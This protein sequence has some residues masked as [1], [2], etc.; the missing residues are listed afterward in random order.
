MAKK[1]KSNQVIKVKS[2][3]IGKTYRFIFAGH[4][5]YTGVL[6]EFNE[7]LTSHYGYQWFT[8]SV[9]ANSADS[10]RMGRDHWRYPSSIFDIIEEIK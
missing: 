10:A 5:E 7:S 1:D 9:P 3:K 8:F 6:I 2:P 4:A